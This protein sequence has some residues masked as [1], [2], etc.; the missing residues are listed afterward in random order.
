MVLAPVL[1]S[2]WPVA[3]LWLSMLAL[4]RGFATSKRLTSAVACGQ[5]FTP[6]PVGRYLL[7]T[8]RKMHW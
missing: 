8:Q 4:Q 3:F 1:F 7:A 5:T 2:F 6:V